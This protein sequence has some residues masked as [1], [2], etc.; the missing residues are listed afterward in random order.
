MR[1]CDSDDVTG[2][3]IGVVVRPPSI[4]RTAAGRRG[5]VTFLLPAGLAVF[6]GFFEGVFAFFGFGV[7]FVTFFATAFTGDGILLVMLI[8]GAVDGD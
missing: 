4:P 3:T 8:I 1:R 5:R 2:R 7:R 6:A